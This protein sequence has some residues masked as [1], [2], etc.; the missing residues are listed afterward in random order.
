MLICRGVDLFRLVQ[1]GLWVQSP[2]LSLT[3]RAKRP[4]FGHH[5]FEENSLS[6]GFDMFLFFVDSRLPHHVW[7]FHVHSGGVGG[8][9]RSD[10]KP[11]NPGVSGPRG[12]ARQ[13]MT[14][15]LEN[16]T[17]STTRAESSP[18]S[19]SAVFR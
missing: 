4:E 9:L 13:R 18:K 17:T 15:D 1:N 16:R 10:Q 2:S 11:R 7:P 12:A 5:M 6:K 19:S 3:D 14:R 8:S